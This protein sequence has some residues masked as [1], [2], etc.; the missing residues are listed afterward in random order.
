LSA[1]ALSRPVQIA[2]AITLVAA[3]WLAWQPDDELAAPVARPGQL[4]S[5]RAPARAPRAAPPPSPP[6]WPLEAAGRGRGTWPAL[7]STARA[8]WEGP[9]VPAAVARAA[10]TAATQAA[11]PPVAPRFP[12]TLIGRWDEA[13]TSRALVL[14]PLRTWVGSPGDVIEG[15][16]RL[17]SVSAT[18]ITVTYLPLSLAQTV[19]MR[20]S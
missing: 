16:W 7:A 1:L 5:P 18:S 6:T 8:A 2:L 4:V 3:A 14:T 11:A 20:P 19:A 15:Q 9:D 10:S 17:D 12:F 13:G